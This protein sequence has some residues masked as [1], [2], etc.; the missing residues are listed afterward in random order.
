M[1]ECK[2]AKIIESM[3]ETCLR[4][5]NKQTNPVMIASSPVTVIITI[6]TFYATI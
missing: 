3:K 5:V 4:N 2:N 6:I 1:I